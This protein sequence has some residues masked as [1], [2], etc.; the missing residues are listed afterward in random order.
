M[1][2]LS[3]IKAWLKITVA[4]YDDQLTELEIRTQA[5]IER[6][7]QWYFGPPRTTVEVLNGTGTSRMF[8]RQP[9]DDGLVVVQDRG[10]SGST[11]SVV[12]P[13]DYELDNRGLYSHGVWPRGLRNHRVTYLEGFTNAPEDIKQLALDLI[14]AVWLRRGSEGLTSETI[15]DYSYSVNDLSATP[16]WSMIVRS[17][18]RGRI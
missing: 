18:K 9:P 3:E 11:W 1:L 10:A 15:G 17:W 6:E 8:L 7:L 2:T 14:S 16:R 4:T 12:D 5:I 13:G